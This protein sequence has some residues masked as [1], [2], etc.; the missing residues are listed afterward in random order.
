MP[1]IKTYVCRKCNSDNIKKNGKNRYGSQ[2]YYCKDCRASGVLEPKIRYTEERKEEILKAYQ[3][4]SSMR[5]LERTFKVARQTVAGWLK[6]KPN[7]SQ[8]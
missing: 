8:L 2:Q 3:E 4:R 5:G 7:L 1:I 6:K